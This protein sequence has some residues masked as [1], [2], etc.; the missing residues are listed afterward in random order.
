MTTAIDNTDRLD[1]LEAE[2][3]QLKGKGAREQAAQDALEAVVLQPPSAPA[4]TSAGREREERQMRGVRAR[5]AAHAEWTRLCDAKA[6]QNASKIA[7]V[8]AEMAELA[9]RRGALVAAHTKDL[10]RLGNEQAKLNA[11]LA[12]LQAPPP[13]PE[14]QYD[15]P[16][17]PPNDL[18]RAARMRL[19]A[20]LE[21][22]GRMSRDDA[23]ARANKVRVA[24]L[25]L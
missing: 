11:K 20:Q 18:V 6:S 4:Q 3:V 7:R 9:Q 8:E 2:I 1:A 13:Q 15:Q 23:I 14:P 24:D 19:V 21:V 5:R 10:S 16:S 22:G 17:P 12:D 25:T